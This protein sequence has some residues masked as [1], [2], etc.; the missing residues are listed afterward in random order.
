MLIH[1]MSSQDDESK[2]MLIFGKFGE[3][4]HCS[5]QLT[6]VGG[7]DMLHEKMFCLINIHGSIYT[8]HP[9]GLAPWGTVSV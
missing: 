6:Q 3:E 9:L 5:D 1:F 4:I 8:A 2:G 7:V